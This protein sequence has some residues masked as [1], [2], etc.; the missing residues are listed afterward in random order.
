M[1]K[2]KTIHNP[3]KS[4]GD[5]IRACVATMT[6]DERVPHV[7]DDREPVDS[8]ESLRDYLRDKGKSIALFSVDDPFEEMAENNAG[9]FYMLMCRTHYGDHAVVC[10]NGVVVHDPAIAKHEIIGP[11]SSGYWIVGVITAI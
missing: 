10:R 2:C 4:Y 5:C 7:F 3:P 1:Y 11:H 6:C 9:I 8:W